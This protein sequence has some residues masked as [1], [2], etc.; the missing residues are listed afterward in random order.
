MRRAATPLDAC[1]GADA[2]VIDTPWPAYRDLVPK[3]IAARMRGRTLIDPYGLLPTPVVTA[4]GLD[5]FTL[6]RS[7]DRASE[8]AVLDA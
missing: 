5:H 3:E 7:V 2:V 6:G 1:D 8:S 4:A